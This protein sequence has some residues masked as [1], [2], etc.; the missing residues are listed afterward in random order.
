MTPGKLILIR[1]GASEWNLKNIFTGFTDVPL[2]EK[3]R[4]EAHQAAVKLKS[5]R[6]DIAYT[7]VLQ[8]AIETLEIILQD[9]KKTD[10]PVVKHAALNERHYG[11]LQGKNK[12]ETRKIFGEQQMKIWRRSFDIRPP[13][14]ESLKDTCDRTIPYFEKEI[15]PKLKE[16]KHVIIAAHGNSL[17]SILMDL[18]KLSPQEIVEVNIP[19][20]VPYVYEFDDQMKMKNKVIL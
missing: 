3:G 12:D 6:L 1:H 5:Y 4:E 17:R 14:G 18:E 20:G 7:S 16:G 11:D 13:N 19:T 10:L 15:L 8:R 9:L 2:A